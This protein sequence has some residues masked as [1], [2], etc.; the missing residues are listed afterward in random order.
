M[1]VGD[2]RDALRGIRAFHDDVDL[3]DRAVDQDF[4]SAT[5]RSSGARRPAADQVFLNDFLDVFLV[6]EGIQTVSSG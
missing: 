5:F 6:D 2:Q 1:R 3:A 4:S